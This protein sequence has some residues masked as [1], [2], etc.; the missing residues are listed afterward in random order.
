[1]TLALEADKNVGT[2]KMGLVCLPSGILEAKDIALPSNRDV[3]ERIGDSDAVVRIVDIRASV[4]SAYK[5]VGNA[6]KSQLTIK[7]EWASSFQEVCT[8]TWGGPLKTRGRDL[9][10]DATV[11]LDAIEQSF[12]SWKADRTIEE[13]C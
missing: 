1:M 2:L 5:G 12:K 11:M 7:V 10:D 3:A 13:G 8:A 6:P 9:R 4:C